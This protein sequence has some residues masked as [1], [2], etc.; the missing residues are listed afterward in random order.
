MNW[1]CEV[2][3]YLKK[4]VSFTA[5][6]VFVIMISDTSIFKTK[7]TESIFQEIHALI[8]ISLIYL[9]SVK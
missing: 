7:S 2:D 1:C 6:D 3:Y 8:Y 5:W 9:W 4:K